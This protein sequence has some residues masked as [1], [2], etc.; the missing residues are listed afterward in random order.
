MPRKM[1]VKKRRTL[2]S[3]KKKQNREEKSEENMKQNKKNNSKLYHN[4]FYSDS[5]SR[6]DRF[7]KPVDNGNVP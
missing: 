6:L 4:L 7:T 5:L 1:D 3:V 2:V